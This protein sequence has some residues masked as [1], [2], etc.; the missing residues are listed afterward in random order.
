MLYAAAARAAKAMGYARIITYTLDS[1]NGA[2][3]K[4]SGWQFM[5]MAGGGSWSVPSRKRVDKAPMCPKK[6]WGKKLKEDEDDEQR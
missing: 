5:R 6:L 4:A 2:S 3:L 1:E